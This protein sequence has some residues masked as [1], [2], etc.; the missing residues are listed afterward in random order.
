GYPGVS[1]AVQV[2]IG[3]FGAYDF[4][5]PYFTTAKVNKISN[6]TSVAYSIRTAGKNL[7]VDHVHASGVQGGI[8]CQLDVPNFPSLARQRIFF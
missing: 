6:G 5:S 2:V 8:V 4:T 1:S 3:W 7:G